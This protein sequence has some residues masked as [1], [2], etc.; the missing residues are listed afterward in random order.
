M[1]LWGYV[2]MVDWFRINGMSE[3]GFWDII[4]GDGIV[5]NEMCE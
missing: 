2:E 4:V 1:E 3:L 5:G